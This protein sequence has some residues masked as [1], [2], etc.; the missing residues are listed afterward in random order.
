MSGKFPAVVNRI[1]TLYNNLD[2]NF[3]EQTIHELDEKM[4]FMDEWLMYKSDYKDKRGMIKNTLLKGLI[5]SM[6]EVIFPILN[7][8][9]LSKIEWANFE[10]LNCFTYNNIIAA[11]D[12]LFF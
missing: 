11:L 4:E 1:R 8:T 7:F 9:Y 2:K 5:T 6:T 3:N 10:V 12:L